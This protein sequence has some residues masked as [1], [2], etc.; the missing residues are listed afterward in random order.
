M[1]LLHSSVFIRAFVQQQRIH[2]E[3]SYHY[4]LQRYQRYWK[5]KYMYVWMATWEIDRWLSFLVVR[6]LLSNDYYISKVLSTPFRAIKVSQVDLKVSEFS[7]KPVLYVH[8]GR[9]GCISTT[10]GY[11]DTEKDENQYSTSGRT[12]NDGQFPCQHLLCTTNALIPE[13]VLLIAPESIAVRFYF[14]MLR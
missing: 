4:N 2:E 10:E 6:S 1:K 5:C 9:V 3:M 14:T 13:V 8:V 7:K 12:N 11:Y